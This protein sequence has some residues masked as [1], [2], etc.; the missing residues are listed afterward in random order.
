[1]TAGVYLDYAAWKSE[2]NSRIK[3]MILPDVDNTMSIYK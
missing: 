2:M 1:M 3:N